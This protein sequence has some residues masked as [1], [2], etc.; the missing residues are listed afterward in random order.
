M[1]VVDSLES[2]AVVAMTVLLRDA[3]A[4]VASGE[5][6][7][8]VVGEKAASAMVGGDDASDAARCL[9]T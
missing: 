3:M 1:I 2:D 4:E 5:A 7:A 6:R 9:C 8:V